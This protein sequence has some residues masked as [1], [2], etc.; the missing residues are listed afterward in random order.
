M[1]VDCLYYSYLEVMLL[2]GLHC[3][4]RGDLVGCISCVYFEGVE[5]ESAYITLGRFSIFSGVCQQSM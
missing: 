1:I 4:E 5:Y 3:M 2:Y